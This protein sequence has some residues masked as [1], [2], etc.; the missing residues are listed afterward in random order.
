MAHLQ[1]GPDDE[2]AETADELLQLRGYEDVLLSL[3][4]P[5]EHL[6]REK[7]RDLL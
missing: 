6:R 2:L 3:F 5:A 4:Q 1:D 7:T